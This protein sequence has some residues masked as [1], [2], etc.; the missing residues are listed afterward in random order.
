MNEEDIKAIAQKVYDDNSASDQFAV[1]TTSFHKHNGQ[2]SPRI[3]FL[4][5]SDVPNSFYQKSGK[6]INITSL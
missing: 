4:N 3:P 5:L 2:D 6:S 1:A